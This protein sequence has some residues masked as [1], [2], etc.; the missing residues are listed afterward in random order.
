MRDFD[1]V[2]NN[3]IELEMSLL[4]SRLEML[5]SESKLV[6][7]LKQEKSPFIN[8]VHCL[9]TRSSCSMGMRWVGL[10]Y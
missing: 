1:Q 3:L 4:C 2:I 6:T 9:C 10:L 8:F 7:L 5:K